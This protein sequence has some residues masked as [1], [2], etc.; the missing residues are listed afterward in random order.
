MQ[1]KRRGKIRFLF[2]AHASEKSSLRLA[3][4]LKNAKRV[5]IEDS[6]D[7]PIKDKLA[8]FKNF[9]KDLSKLTRA[10]RE[11]I[12][13][14]H[15]ISTGGGED[16]NIA[17]HM[18]PSLRKDAKLYFETGTPG[19]TKRMDIAGKKFDNAF[20]YFMGG[21]TRKVLDLLKEINDSERY[22]HIDPRESN[23]ANDI[24]KAFKEDPTKDLYVFTGSF[25]FPI[26][27]IL[28]KRGLPVSEKIMGKTAVFPPGLEILRRREYGKPLSRKEEN[29]M[30]FRDMLGSALHKDVY[31]DKNIYAEEAVA[32]VRRV[33][34]RMKM[35][36]MEELSA[37]LDRAQRSGTIGI[38]ERR[39]ISD[40]IRYWLT[41]KGFAKSGE[42]E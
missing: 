3:E 9:R 19:V 6:T 15:T 31:E 13:R 40:F 22:V 34:D 42:L 5:F 18:F 30:L 37:R 7:K 38:H 26:Y 36:D 21:K 16:V 23:M 39:A 28:K 41:K 20:K 24:E 11:Y 2:G 25:H 12:A 27:R 32:R 1:R 33:L 29:I 8:T 35:S 4:E 17:V 10:E 14:M